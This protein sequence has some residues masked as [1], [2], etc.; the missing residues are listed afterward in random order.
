M[1][2]FC[3]GCFGLYSNDVAMDSGET[4]SEEI[5]NELTDQ[6][7]ADYIDGVEKIGFDEA[8]DKVLEEQGIE[9]A[10]VLIGLGK[11][12]GTAFLYSAFAFATLV[13][14]EITKKFL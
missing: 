3:M 2:F 1:F 14:V 8:I 7:I 5:S 4:I 13:S 9:L 10:D 12:M 6:K 11:E